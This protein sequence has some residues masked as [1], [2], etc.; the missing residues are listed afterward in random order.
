[1]GIC[2]RNPFKRCLD[3]RIEANFNSLLGQQMVVENRPK[4][5]P[6]ATHLPGFE[7]NNW[8]AM[9][10]PA[11]TPKEMVPLLNAK[12]ANVLAMPDLRERLVDQGAVVASSTPEQMA[13]IIKSDLA[14][15]AKVAKNA[16]ARVE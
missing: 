16:G 13:T 11:D 3:Q 5:R 15:W 14:K 7:A 6:T 12:I 8:F 1:M 9:L 2:F 10:A 4:P